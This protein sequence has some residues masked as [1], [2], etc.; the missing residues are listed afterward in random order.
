MTTINQPAIPSSLE[1]DN[2]LDYLEKEK[3]E[4]DYKE[5]TASIIDHPQTSLLPDLWEYK[6]NIPR[7]KED[8]R[9]KIL[10]NLYAAI[11]KVGFKNAKDW[12]KKIHI[13]GSLTTNLYRFDSDI[14]INVQMDY[15][16]FRKNNPDYFISDNYRLRNYIRDQVYP[17]LN[18]FFFP[19]RKIKYF[20]IGLDFFLEADYYYDL[21]ENEWMDGKVPVLIESSYDPDKVFFKEKA[22]AVR[23]IKIYNVL[24]ERISLCIREVGK[25]D[26]LLKNYES[27]YLNNIKN[28]LGKELIRRF[29]RLREMDKQMLTFREMRFKLPKDQLNFSGKD[30]SLNWETHNVIYKYIEFFGYKDLFEVLEKRIPTEY[31]Y[32]YEFYR[33]KSKGG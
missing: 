30:L 9:N 1:K 18:V 23:A 13:V 22:I 24:I 4:L 12:V 29:K 8:I 2:F 20:I 6:K 25:I 28:I 11:N 7:I 3:E 15:N 10:D 19:K 32:L 5:R 17:I 26:D 31:L 27:I 16:L 21:I 33:D 14:D